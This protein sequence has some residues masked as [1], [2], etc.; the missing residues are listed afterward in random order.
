[1]KL[2]ELLGAFRALQSLKVKR[3]EGEDGKQVVVAASLPAKLMYALVKNERL[4]EADLKAHDAG[5]LA[6]LEKAG[7]EQ[8]KEIPEEKREE[9]DKEYQELIGTEVE[10]QPYK[11]RLSLLEGLELDAGQMNA[12]F[13]MIEE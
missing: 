4:M 5:Y 8:G 13:W 9:A 3:V 6:I 10:F 2:I 12:L 11:I 7:V 1:M